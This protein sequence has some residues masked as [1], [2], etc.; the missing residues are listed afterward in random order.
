MQLHFQSSCLNLPLDI[1][2]LYG[3][4]CLQTWYYFRNYH[5]R[6]LLR[7]VVSSSQMLSSYRANDTD[8][9]VLAI[10]VLETAH[11]IL[12][13]HAVYHYLVLNFANPAGLSKHVWLVISVLVYSRLTFSPRSIV[14]SVNPALLLY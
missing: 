5:D 1:R 4:T 10:L 8:L 7:G 3:V 11:A 13:I 2:S 6:W 12:A 14:V 9:Q